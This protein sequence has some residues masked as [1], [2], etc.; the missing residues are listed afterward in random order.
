MNTTVIVLG[1]ILLLVILYMIF[2][3]YFTGKTKLTDENL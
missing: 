1:T 3:D 2:Q